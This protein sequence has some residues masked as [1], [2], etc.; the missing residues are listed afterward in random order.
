MWLARRWAWR[1]VP[2]LSRAGFYRVRY[3]LPVIVRPAHDSLHLITQPDHA[4]LAAKIIEH[5]VSLA[6]RPRRDAILLAV[7][8]HDNGWTEEDD[9]P[10]LNPATGQL[11]DFI[12]VPIEVRHRVWPCAVQRLAQHPWTAALVAEH[13]VVV[14]DRFRAEP[15]WEPFFSG[16][17]AARDD[18]VRASGLPMA[19]LVSDYEFVRLADLISL[20][21]CM[22]IPH[23]Q[24][25][26]EWTVKLTGDHVVVTPDPF[27][28]WVIPV[29]I[30]ARVLPARTFGS[31]TELRS[32]VNAAE[33]VMV[34]GTVSGQK[35]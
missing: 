33:R 25:F 20:L 13:A 1:L 27:G 12:N 26:A 16:M 9:A 4:H 24:R 21:F 29:E 14:Y 18:M 34:K 6:A 3:D 7:A 30:Q 19:A 28:Q 11:A 8:E 35:S 15:D 10:M 17:E 23:P 2:T 32:A 5:S 22:G 31:D